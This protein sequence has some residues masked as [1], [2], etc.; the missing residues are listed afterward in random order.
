[1]TLMGEIE[2]EV[3][4][5]VEFVLRIAQSRSRSGMVVSDRDREE[6]VC[7]CRMFR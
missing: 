3:E 7:I 1:M 6:E 4:M 5:V 2:R